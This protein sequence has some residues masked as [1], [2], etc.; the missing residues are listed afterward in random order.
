MGVLLSYSRA[1]WANLV[2]AFVVMLVVSSMR[3]T[4]ARRALRALIVLLATGGAVLVLLSA[5]GAVGF[6]EHRAQLQSYDTQRFAAQSSAGNWAGPTP[7]GSDRGSSTPTSPWT[8][9]STFVRVFAE[10]GPFGLLI[11]IALLLATLVFALRN[12]VV[13]RDTYGIGSAALLGAGA[14]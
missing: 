7:W 10:Q 11:W 12:V 13:G 9:H 1:A 14:A 5:T 4:G 6:L 2:I 3:R 8:R